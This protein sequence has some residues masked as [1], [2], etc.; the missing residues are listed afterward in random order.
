[1]L[2][3]V[4]LIEFAFVKNKNKKLDLKQKYILWC[5]VILYL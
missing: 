5:I 1:M 3:K 4:L 2:I